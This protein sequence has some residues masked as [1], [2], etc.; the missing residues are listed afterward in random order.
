MKNNKG[1]ATS[2]IIFSLL[3]LFL[4]VISMVLLTLSNSSV[5]NSKLK[6]KL[7][8][9]AETAN[10]YNEYNFY[11]LGN[12][13]QVFKA[14]RES[15]YKI[16][17]WSQN[18]NYTFG[19]IKLQKNQKLYIYVGPNTANDGNVIIRTKYD[20]TDETSIIMKSYQNFAESSVSTAFSTVNPT[21]PSSYKRENDT[22]QNIK[23]PQVR[24][25]YISLYANKVKYDGN[26]VQNCNSQDDSDNIGCVLDEIADSIGSE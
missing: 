14:P 15:T 3:V 8:T 11:Y 24:I 12:Q 2:F 13:L 16:E 20:M 25:S 26:V 19:K 10:V 5:L 21:D 23:P 17:A 7:K 18:R 4:V 9:D 22:T 1:F 6:D